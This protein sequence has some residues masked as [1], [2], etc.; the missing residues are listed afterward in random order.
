MENLINKIKDELK[1]A[2]IDYIENN[3]DA[4]DQEELTDNMLN[5]TTFN[6][7]LPSWYDSP[8]KMMKNNDPIMYNETK[9]N[10]IDSLSQENWY[11][12]INDELYKT[13]DIEDA[14]FDFHSELSDELDAFIND[15]EL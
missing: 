7:D 11:I 10:S 9:A 6:E 14:R 2:L 15:I 8:A 13:D 12:M 4:V 3:V 5:E 1:S